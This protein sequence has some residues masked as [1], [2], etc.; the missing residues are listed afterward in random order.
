[1]LDGLGGHH[2][3]HIRAA[4]GVADVTGAAAHQDH[5]AVPGHL[6]A[7]HQAQGHEVPNVEAVRRGVKSDVEGGFAGVHQLP[8]FLLIGHLGD[9]ATGFQFFVNL[10]D[11]S[12]F[13][14]SDAMAWARKN[15]LCHG[16]D[17]GRQISWYHLFLPRSH[18]RGLKGSG[19]AKPHAR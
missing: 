10:H 19:I 16:L 7:L 14:T 11:N 1:M 13:L 17:R 18:K 4:G 2:G 3:T 12:P 8:D 5:R 6:Q 9:E 15:A